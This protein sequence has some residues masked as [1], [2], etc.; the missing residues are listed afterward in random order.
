[1]TKLYSIEI[2]SINKT[3]K[4]KK[5]ICM[6][7]YER[8]TYFWTATNSNKIP[9]IFKTWIFRMSDLNYTLLYQHW[10]LGGMVR[11]ADPSDTLWSHKNPRIHLF[12]FLFWPSYY[13]LLNSRDFSSSYFFIKSKVN[14]AVLNVIPNFINCFTVF[15]TPFRYCLFMENYVHFLF[16]VTCVYILVRYFLDVHYVCINCFCVNELI[17]PSIDSELAYH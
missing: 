11:V 3:F 5:W 6:N 4:T 1:M 17:L 15:V 13:S 10:L 2:A 14:M 8:C 12:L 7:I 16:I 9:N